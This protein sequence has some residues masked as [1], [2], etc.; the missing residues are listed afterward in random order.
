MLQSTSASVRHCT[1]PRR[2]TSRPP[3]MTSDVLH[4]LPLFVRRTIRAALF[5]QLMKVH[6]FPRCVRGTSAPR[7]NSGFGTPALVW[8]GSGEP[9]LR[10]FAAWCRRWARSVA[11]ASLRRVQGRSFV[12]DLGVR[13]CSIEPCVDRSNSEYAAHALVQLTSLRRVCSIRAVSWAGVA[14]LRQGIDIST[15]RV[16][17]SRGTVKRAVQHAGGGY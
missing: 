15:P 7:P 9:A 10:P 16:H 14:H 17:Q 3:A 1:A 11:D 12:L 4:P 2:P 5:S 6:A 13:W 8:G